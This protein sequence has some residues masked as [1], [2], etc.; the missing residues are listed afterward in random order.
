M[1][2]SPRRTLLVVTALLVAALGGWTAAQAT[3]TPGPTPSAYIPLDPVRVLDHRSTPTAD[4]ALRL[5]VGRPL[6][7]TLVGTTVPEGTTAVTVNVTVVAPT[8]AGFVTVRAAD[9]RGRPSTSTVNFDAGATIANST[10]VALSRTGAVRFVYDAYAERTGELQ[11]VVDVLGYYAPIPAGAPGPAGPA[12]PMGPTGP[13]G[14]PGAT[15]ATGPQ[16]P[17]GGGI[18]PAAYVDTSPLGPDGAGFAF[19]TVGT[20]NSEMVLTFTTAATSPAIVQVIVRA[21]LVPGA[22]L[23]GPVTHSAAPVQVFCGLRDDPDPAADYRHEAAGSLA[24]ATYLFDSDTLVLTAALPASASASV[25]CQAT[26]SL[27]APA[28][29]AFPLGSAA[30]EFKVRFGI[31]SIIG[32]AVSDTNAGVIGRDL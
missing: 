26:P 10:T 28:P 22:D 21:S 19:I 17:A 4:G 31:T 3:G 8:R 20:T 6:D 18:A 29:G 23:T 30:D 24:P 11:L 1:T 7:L 32:T 12:G 14:F 25:W 16:G 27:A 15:G 2:A 13:M 5:R 9:A